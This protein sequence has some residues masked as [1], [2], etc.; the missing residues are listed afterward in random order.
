[1]TI[2][3]AAVPG[4]VPT[5]QHQGQDSALQL[6]FATCARGAAML[7]EIWDA[8]LRPEY[9]RHLGLSKQD[10]RLWV[11]AA[12][13]FCGPRKSRKARERIKKL[14]TRRGLS[15]YAL[16]GIHSELLKLK[17]DRHAEIAEILEEVVTKVEGTV[18]EIIAQ[19]SEI[20]RQHNIAFEMKE[21][22]RLAAEGKTPAP[23]FGKFFAVTTPDAAGNGRVGMVYP[24]SVAAAIQ[25]LTEREARQLMRTSKNKLSLPEAMA[26]ISS[27]KLLTPLAEDGSFTPSL[28]AAGGLGPLTPFVVMLTEDYENAKNKK[29]SA[30]LL[31]CTDGSVITGTEVMQRGFTDQRYFLVMDADGTPREVLRTRPKK[32]AKNSDAELENSVTVM[33]GKL[34]TGRDSRIANPKQRMVAEAMSLQCVWPGCE[35]PASQSQVHHIQ[36][37]TYGGETAPENLTMLCR[38]HNAANDDGPNIQLNGRIIREGWETQYLPPHSTQPVKDRSP[39]RNLT[40]IALAQRRSQESEP[41]DTQAPLETR[42]ATDT[43]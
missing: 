34:D 36:A 21:Q 37:W 25:E 27:T 26:Q 33:T 8:R 28:S 17:S 4:Q 41:G 42:P 12:R 11:A 22:E 38:V 18:D 14:I 13:T 32:N 20:I 1:M 31:G 6:F 2:S 29:A 5:T 39:I 15:I 7:Q 40:A 24:S 3:S 16:V 23:D 19:A 43:G 9:L 35:R 10:A 30:T